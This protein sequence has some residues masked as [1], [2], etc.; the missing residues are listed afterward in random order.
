MLNDS[1]KVTGEV[2]IKVFGPNGE[3]KK[4]LNKSNLVVAT[5]KNFIASRVARN[6]SV[7]MSHMA[8]GTGGSQVAVAADATLNN[9]LARI[10]IATPVVQNNV[11]TFTGVFGPTF[12]TGTLSEAGIFNSPT[13][14]TMLCRTTFPAVEKEEDDIIAVTWSITIN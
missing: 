5:G 8:V 4:E 10:P 1:L 14:G 6:D 9:Q 3:L 7:P 12:G 13:A 11:I 2:N